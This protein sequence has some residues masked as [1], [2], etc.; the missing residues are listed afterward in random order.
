MS[1]TGP[2][3]IGHGTPLVIVG[4]VCLF[5]KKG[6]DTWLKSCQGFLEERV[7]CHPELKFKKH[8]GFRASL[9]CLLP[10]NKQFNTQR[11]TELKRTQKSSSKAS[12]QA[13]LEM[14]PICNYIGP[15]ISSSIFWNQC[16]LFA[17]QI[18]LT[19]IPAL[20]GIQETHLK[21]IDEKSLKTK[22]R[23]KSYQ[24][25]VGKQQAEMAES[26]SD[27]K[28]LRHKQEKEAYY[29]FPSIMNEFL[30]TKYYSSKIWNKLNKIGL[31]IFQKSSQVGNFAWEFDESS[32]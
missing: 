17:T 26:R 9:C 3:L 27:K 21:Q 28:N 8:G 2:D 19:D 13:R 7:A 30:Y 11:N 18:T 25:N 4:F 6:F 16:T 14:K 22:A 12:K 32:K 15:N 5:F 31:T 10:W 24:A 23:G 20:C 1:N 29:L